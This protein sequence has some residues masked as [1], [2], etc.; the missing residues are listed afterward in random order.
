MMA[1]WVTL[2]EAA[3]RLGVDTTEITSRAQ[4]GQIPTRPGTDPAAGDLLFGLPDDA[5]LSGSRRSHRRRRRRSGNSPISAWQRDSMRRTR[6]TTYAI[7]V[8]LLVAL[9]T[10]LTIGRC[11][12][13]SPASDVAQATPA[14]VTAGAVG[15]SDQPPG[16]L[17]V[18]WPRLE[19][20]WLDGTPTSG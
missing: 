1:I 12:P 20:I 11:Q 4:R 13:A 18:A 3:R 5:P 15:R 10:G 14:R 6:F 16:P 19:P 8:I 2:G 7:L 17:P 9:I